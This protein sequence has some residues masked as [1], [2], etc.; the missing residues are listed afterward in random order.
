MGWISDHTHTRLGGRKPYT[1]LGA[2]LCGVAFFCL[3]NPPASLTNA[4]RRFGSGDVHPLIHISHRLCSAALRARLGTHAESFTSTPACSR[5]AS[6]ITISERSWPQLPPALCASI[7]SDRAPG[8]LRARNLLLPHAQCAVRLVGAEY[9]GPPGTRPFT[10]ASKRYGP[11]FRLP[12]CWSGV[13]LN[14]RGPSL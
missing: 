10:L 4:A 12:P 11:S 1:L 13:D 14:C 6:L 9:K 5:G 3:L 7:P 2:P 8:V